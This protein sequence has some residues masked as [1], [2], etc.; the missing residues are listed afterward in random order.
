MHCSPVDFAFF[1][2]GL[3]ICFDHNPPVLATDSM[4]CSAQL[5]FGFH[6]QLAHISNAIVAIPAEHISVP[7]RQLPMTG[8]VVDGRPTLYLVNFKIFVKKLQKDDAYYNKKP[9]EVYA[10]FK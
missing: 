3:L 9:L 2:S 1:P 10:F 8:N 5:A 6:I 4:C 7:S